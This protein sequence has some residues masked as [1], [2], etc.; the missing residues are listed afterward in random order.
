MQN[1]KEMKRSLSMTYFKKSKVKPQMEEMWKN[2]IRHTCK[3]N[4]KIE[5]LPQRALE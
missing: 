1:F 2:K 4:I 3:L 5:N